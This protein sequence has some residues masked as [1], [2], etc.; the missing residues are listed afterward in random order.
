MWWQHE[1]SVPKIIIIYD[2]NETIFETKVEPAL[3]TL[4]IAMKLFQ[5]KHA[6]SLNAVGANRCLLQ[7]P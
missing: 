4:K 7:Y 3:N 2:F 6:D 5:C 1:V